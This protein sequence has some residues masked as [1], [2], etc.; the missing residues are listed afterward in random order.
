MVQNEQ[1]P[2]QANITLQAQVPRLGEGGY[3][4]SPTPLGSMADDIRCEDTCHLPGVQTTVGEGLRAADDE[5]KEGRTLWADDQ[6]L[7]HSSSN[8]TS[9]SSISSS[10]RSRTSVPNSI[11]SSG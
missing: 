4:L 10:S 3:S 5:V 6:S 2:V 1:L 7:R 9:P 11:H 8:F